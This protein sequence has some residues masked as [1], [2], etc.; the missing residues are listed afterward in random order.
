MVSYF[1]GNEKQETPAKIV[2]WETL[3]I[4]G[5]LALNLNF[6]CHPMVD[7]DNLIQLSTADVFN[8]ITIVFKQ[9]KMFLYL[10]FF[11]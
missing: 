11:I 7:R 1:C 10:I 9:P 8:Y 3:K 2:H 5:S 6:F 4:Q